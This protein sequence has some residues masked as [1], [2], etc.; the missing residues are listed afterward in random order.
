MTDGVGMGGRGGRLSRVLLSALGL[1]FVWPCFRA[2]GLTFY[3]VFGVHP[4]EYVQLAYWAYVAVFLLGTLVVLAFPDAAGR[5]LGRPRAALALGA[6]GAAGYAAVWASSAT[7]L[8]PAA[9][10]VGS[11]AAT[12]SF[13]GLVVRYAMALSAWDAREAAVVGFASFGVCFLDNAALAAGPAVGL[14][15]LVA[16]P[17]ATGLC[18]PGLPEAGEAGEAPA[19]GPGGAARPV[20]G[21]SE[22]FATLLALMVLLA[23]FSIVGNAVRGITSPW[24]AYSRPTWR[25]AYMSAANLALA[26]VSIAL[27][28][29]GVDVRKVLFWN[30]TAF[31]ALF[32]LGLAAIA[33]GGGALAQLGSDVATVSR[34]CFTLLMFLF[35]VLLSRR[36]GMGT[37]RLVGLF[38]LLPESLAAAIRHLLVP[39]LLARLGQDPLALAAR[40]GVLAI[41]ILIVAITVVLGMLLLRQLDGAG[42]ADGASQLHGGAG[43]AGAESPLP[44]PGAPGQDEGLLDRLAELYGLTAR[45]SEAVSYVS[46]G[47]SLE[48]TAQLLGI[49]I[50]TV[51][52]HMRSAYGKLGVHSR[53][54]L[55]DLL[56]SMRG[57]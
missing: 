51:R 36:A 38:L 17:L 28:C 1:S 11:A 25:S 14:L 23:L 16:A 26:C 5:A 44:G 42:G 40:A 52:T 47:Y 10:A 6:V 55:I 31:M 27:L 33:F 20:E 34:V 8:A 35:A 29:R 49:S 21:R 45:E 50:N 24:F 30:W 54:G 43:G 4:A 48:K 3:T 2:S 15:Y 46:R 32:F 19:G 57:R 18:A 12:A 56:D 22:L 41:L 13:V 7:A 37:V 53:Q 39:V 9:C